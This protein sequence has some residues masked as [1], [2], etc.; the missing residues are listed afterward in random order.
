MLATPALLPTTTLLPPPL[1][2]TVLLTLTLMSLALPT[3]P[4]LLD[5]CHCPRPAEA[6][7]GAAR[8]R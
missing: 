8:R 2:L 1:P 7:A 4:M 5:P 3:L 6:T